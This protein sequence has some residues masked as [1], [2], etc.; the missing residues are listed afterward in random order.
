MISSF[1]LTVALDFDLLLLA[2][3]PV[4]LF[5]LALPPTFPF[6]LLLLFLLLFFINDVL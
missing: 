3:A 1:L 2:L 4:F 6:L 5:P